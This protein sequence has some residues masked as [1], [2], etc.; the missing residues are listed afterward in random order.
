MNL[1]SLLLASVLF[2]QSSIYAQ[3]PGFIQ[4]WSVDLGNTN[5]TLVYGVG[6]DG[7]VLVTSNLRDSYTWLSPTGGVIGKIPSGE[8]L[9]TGTSNSFDSF[10]VVFAPPVEFGGS[11][12]Q[13]L[14]LWATTGAYA[15]NSAYAFRRRQ[16]TDQ[17]NAVRGNHCPQRVHN[18]C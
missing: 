12:E 9:P 14:R 8:F 10:V 6:R 11:I 1:R 4:K 3:I 16:P 17:Q 7:S 2:L 13:P 15:D 5:L 18:N